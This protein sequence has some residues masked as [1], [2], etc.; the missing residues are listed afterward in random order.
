MLKLH[1][2]QVSTMRLL[3]LL[4]PMLSASKTVKSRRIPARV[5]PTR[6]KFEAFDSDVSDDDDDD[7][8]SIMRPLNA[9]TSNVEL[10]SRKAKTQ[11]AK[12]RTH[13]D[14]A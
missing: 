6:N 13:H 3:Y 7:K 5:T 9:M 2:R 4:W 1:L 14:L 8:E 10:A 11:R 12:E